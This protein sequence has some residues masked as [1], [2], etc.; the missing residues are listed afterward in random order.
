MS[1]PSDPPSLAP[2][3]S[4]AAWLA[5]ALVIL[6]SLINGGLLALYRGPA[7]EWSAEGQTPPIDTCIRAA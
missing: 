1:I 2:R 3:T 4:R 7:S 5:V 6:A